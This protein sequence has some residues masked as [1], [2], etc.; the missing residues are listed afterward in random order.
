[1]P[2][3]SQTDRFYQLIWPHRAD[4]LR[5]ALML[6][7]DHAEAEDL[8]QQTLVKAFR[9]LDGFTAGTNARAWLSRILRNARIDSLRT[10]ATSEPAV[11]LEQ[12]SEE[13]PAP[14]VPD[15]PGAWTDPDELLTSFSDEQV[16]AALRELPEA[17]RWTLLLVDV[18][19]MD[20][21]AAAEVLEVP[22]GTIKSRAHRGRAMLR[23]SLA[24][25]GRELRL[26]R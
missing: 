1:M 20:H 7:H 22:E 13:P 23:Q 15:E 14:P 6:T 2:R 11:S 8:A 19:G 5:L 26:I 4:V 12:L 25:I 9:G 16:I 3:P 18:A 10:Q 17:I 24:A 21:A